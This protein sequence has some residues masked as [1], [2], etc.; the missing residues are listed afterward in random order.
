[1]HQAVLIVNVRH[2]EHVGMVAPGQVQN[3][4]ILL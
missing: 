4:T 3:D 2:A 1:M